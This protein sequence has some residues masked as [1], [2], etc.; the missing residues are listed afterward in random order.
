MH[1]LCPGVFK[2]SWETIKEV[3]LVCILTGGTMNFELGQTAASPR[4]QPRLQY[5]ATVRHF[6]W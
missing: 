6:A 1:M 5:L 3:G 2:W 4:T